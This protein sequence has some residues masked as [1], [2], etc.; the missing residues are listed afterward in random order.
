MR[1]APLPKEI[2]SLWASLGVARQAGNIIYDD[3]AP[4]AAI[5][6]ALTQQYSDIL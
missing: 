3:D 2:D 5:R 1:A 4:L 6:R